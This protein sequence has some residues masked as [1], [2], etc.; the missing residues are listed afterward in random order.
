MIQEL[1]TGTREECPH[2]IQVLVQQGGLPSGAIGREEFLSTLVVGL[3]GKKL[4]GT[5]MKWVSHW[6]L[7]TEDLLRE[8]F[9]VQGEKQR[10]VCRNATIRYQLESLDT[11]N[12]CVIGE[13]VVNA[14]GF[15]AR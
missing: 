8:N 1:L 11:T 13:H 3:G 6:L 5:S 9:I 4:F 12:K 14:A 15:T 2:L 10:R 7:R